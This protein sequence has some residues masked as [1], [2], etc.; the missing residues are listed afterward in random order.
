MPCSIIE[1]STQPSAL[2]VPI[3]INPGY[4]PGL[5][6][7]CINICFASLPLFVPTIISEMGAFTSIQANGLSAPPYL[8]CWI[9]IIA[10]TFISD[11]TKTIR[12]PFV[13]VP[14]LVA[15]IGYILLGTSKTVAVRYFGLFLATQI[16]ISVAM[17]LTWVA[18]THATDSKRAG[19]FAILATFGQ[20]GPVLGTNIFPK[21]DAPYYRKGMWISCGAC[22]MVFVLACLQ[23]TLL[24]RANKK[25]DREY[26]ANRDFE[27]IDSGGGMGFDKRF[28]Y[29]I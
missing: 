27:H 6:Y 5:I 13:A 19:A 14:G 2:A 28:R 16:F 7:F 11:R 1:V 23:S 9:M 3:D 18:N 15:A 26:G 20:C 21:S 10:I 29:V 22:I 25:R 24:W 17:T 4:I 12:G 8:L